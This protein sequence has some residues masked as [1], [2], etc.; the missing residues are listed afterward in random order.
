M[1]SVSVTSVSHTAAARPPDTL[2]SRRDQLSNNNNSD[3]TAVTEPAR[4][5]MGT[6]DPTPAVLEQSD[7]CYTSSLYL[8]HP[9]PGVVYSLLFT[10]SRSRFTSS[11]VLCGI[12]E[13]A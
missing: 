5:T 9:T 2:V 4:T 13:K 12:V 10:L 11:P 8:G 3:K 1:T 7:Q 6:A